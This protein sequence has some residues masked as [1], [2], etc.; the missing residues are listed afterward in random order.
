MYEEAATASNPVSLS[1]S[2]NRPASGLN[3]PPFAIRPLFSSEHSKLMCNLSAH[4]RISRCKILVV[5]WYAN[6]I[7]N[8]QIANAIHTATLSLQLRIWTLA[9]TWAFHFDSY[10]ERLSGSPFF[11]LFLQMWFLYLMVIIWFY[12]N[13]SFTPLSHTPSHTQSPSPGAQ[14]IIFVWIIHI[15]V[16]HMFLYAK[17]MVWRTTHCN[18]LSWT[19]RRT[20][21]C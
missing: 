8:Y 18:G 19:D 3:T 4:L 15:W 21:L 17:V 20:N 7:R 2:L 13:T 14:A 12:K 5:A 11:S 9:A 6:V 1:L 16:P 10:I